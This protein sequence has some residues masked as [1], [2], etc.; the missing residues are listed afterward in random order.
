MKASS[1]YDVEESWA[2]TNML[3]GLT[4]DLNTSRGEALHSNSS[5]RQLVGV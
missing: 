1:R 4:M 2:E 5:A 3:V